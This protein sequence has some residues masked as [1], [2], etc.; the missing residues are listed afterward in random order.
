[1]SASTPC[2]QQSQFQALNCMRKPYL[3]IQNV[4]RPTTVNKKVDLYL[5]GLSEQSNKN[6]ALVH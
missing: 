5:A 4:D 2:V 3:S 1:M 6:K